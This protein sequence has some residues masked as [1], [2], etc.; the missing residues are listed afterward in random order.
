M[1]RRDLGCYPPALRLRPPDD[2]HR[3]RGRDVAYVQGRADV[4]GQQ[5]V[6]GDDRFLGDGGPARQPEEPGHLALVHLGGV[7]QPGLLGVLRNHAAERLDVLQCPTHQHRVRH[8]AAIVRED[9]DPGRRVRH[10]AE[11][12][13][14]TALK[15]DRDRADRLY[16][17][18][19]RLPA[20]A[21]D[22]LDDACSVGDRV[23]IGHRVDGGEAAERG[24]LGAGPHGL[25]VLPARLA[26]VRVQVHEAG[27]RNQAGG[28]QDL[29]AGGAQAAPGL[30]DQS[31]RKDQVSDSAAHQLRALDEP[32]LAAA[33][34]VTCTA[35]ALAGWALPDAPAVPAVPATSEITGRPPGSAPPSSKYRTAIRTL[36]P[37]ATCSTIVERGESATSAAI[38]TP[39]FI[40]PGCIT[41]ACSGSR[42]IRAA[43]RPYLRLYSRTVGK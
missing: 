11:L 40:G 34:L 22:L 13:K 20:E 1:M 30:G 4:R 39:R 32:G 41:I 18:V 33:H 19:A 28:V 42:A 3:A 26:Q 43:S 2:L 25:S 23:G 10:G 36:T 29:R 35:T 31:V 8:A 21:P 5:A 38:S 6:P 16:V 12:G 37:F 27:Q 17:A 14:L 15:A 7:G 24:R 9:P